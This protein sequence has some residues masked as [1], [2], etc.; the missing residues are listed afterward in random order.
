MWKLLPQ[1]ISKVQ[2]LKYLS[3]AELHPCGGPSE[4]SSCTLK[5]YSESRAWGGYT[6]KSMGVPLT[7]WLSAECN[8]SPLIYRQYAGQG[9]FHRVCFKKRK[10][11][12]V[13]FLNLMQST[14]K[15]KKKLDILS[16]RAKKT[17][18]AKCF[19]G[20]RTDH[21]GW[22]LLSQRQPLASA[23]TRS[24]VWRRRFCRHGSL[25]NFNT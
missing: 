7:E 12:K 3:R 5:G 24:Q 10:K 17:S 19:I 21:H 25:L 16:G 18:S 2:V 1:S 23:N 22:F 14:W 13:S 15:K 11:E 4:H 9:A 8:A 6:L 20:T